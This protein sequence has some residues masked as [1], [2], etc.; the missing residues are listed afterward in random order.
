LGGVAGRAKAAEALVAKMQR[1][2]AAIEREAKKK[3]RRLRVYCEAWPNPRISSPP[4]VAEL[5]RLCGGQMI[6]PAGAQVSEEQ[7]AAANP[8]VIVRAGK[9]RGKR[10]MT[11][12][13]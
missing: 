13:G 4:W 1:G 7:A 5:V 12:A 9:A 3:K 11:N 10:A 8:C 6:V 2:F